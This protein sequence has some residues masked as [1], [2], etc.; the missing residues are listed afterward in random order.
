MATQL[1]HQ[2]TNFSRDIPNIIVVCDN[3]ESPANI[4]S[5]FRTCDAL[6][7]SQILFCGST[8]DLTSSRLKRTARNSVENTPH[9]DG[10]H[11]I[12]TLQS[13]SFNT[14]SIVALEL[15]THSI[16]IEQYKIDR[17]KTTV[18]IIGNEKHGISAEALELAHK[19]IHIEMLGKNS[20]MNVINAASI[21]LFALTK[22]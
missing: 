15:T 13:F 11:I 2:Q 10:L 18:L 12:D 6:G 16:P 22:F 8:L 9:R 3:V 21:A 17:T 14:H 5:L 19:S 20:S 1:S 4:G 7:V